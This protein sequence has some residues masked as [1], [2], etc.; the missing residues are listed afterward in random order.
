MKFRENRKFKKKEIPI[1]KNLERGI[2]FCITALLTSIQNSIMV[3]CP[4]HH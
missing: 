2:F 4:D 3:I 1:P